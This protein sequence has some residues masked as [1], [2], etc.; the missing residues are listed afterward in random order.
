MPSRFR[1]S[2]WKAAARAAVDFGL[3]NLNAAERPCLG[4][5]G[6]RCR[7]GKAAQTEERVTGVQDSL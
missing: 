5:R 6:P 2:D 7:P 1:Y 4:P 3:R